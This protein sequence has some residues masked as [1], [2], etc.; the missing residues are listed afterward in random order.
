[1]KDTEKKIFSFINKNLQVNTIYIYGSY[2]TDNFRD[3][4]DIDIALIPC[5]KIVPVELFDL[6]CD[7]AVITNTDIDLVDFTQATPVLKSQ[8]L[9]NNKIVFCNDHELRLYHEMTA[10]KEYSMHN[11][12]CSII[13]EA[14][15]GYS[16]KQ[17]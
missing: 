10:L 1:M 11:E 2:I 7:L 14:M 9:K 3:N 15:Y 12:E 13:Y 8:I 6:S 17:D 5:Q 16:I 4:S